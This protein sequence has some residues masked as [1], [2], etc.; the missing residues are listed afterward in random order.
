MRRALCQPLC[1]LCQ[2]L[3]RLCRPLCQPLCH[4][5]RP[6]C[7]P[8][9]H[10]CIHPLDNRPKAQTC[11]VPALCR[12]TQGALGSWQHFWASSHRRSPWKFIKPSS[13]LRS[14]LPTLQTP[15]S[16]LSSP[17][18]HRSGSRDAGWPARGTACL[19]WMSELDALRALCALRALTPYSPYLRALHALRALRAH[20]P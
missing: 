15:F 2:P 1:H 7:H 12:G 13:S 18:A 8:L 10:S 4:L 6:L 19:S 20:A 5:C 14:S 9:F 17:S 11:L 3:C 16:Q